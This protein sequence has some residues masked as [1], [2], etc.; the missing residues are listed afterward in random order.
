MSRPGAEARN[1][2][3]PCTG[4]IDTEMIPI[5][6]ANPLPVAAGAAA[7]AVY[8]NRSLALAGAASQQLMAANAARKILIVSNPAAT[9]IA[10]N[11]IGGAAV[12]NGAGSITLPQNGSI[13]IDTS[14]PNGIINVIGTNAAAVTAYEA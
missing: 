4:D 5:G 2:F 3:V 8:T 6:P 13:I 1:F 11:L 10:V 7:A 14:P 9:P 12:L